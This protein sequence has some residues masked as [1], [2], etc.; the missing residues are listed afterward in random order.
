VTIAVE[1]VLRYQRRCSVL[2]PVVVKCV[3]IG[4]LLLLV[5]IITCYYCWT[6]RCC[7]MDLCTWARCLSRTPVGT[8]AWR[9]TMAACNELKLTS[10]SSQVQ[11]RLIRLFLYTY[12]QAF[13]SITVNS[14]PSLKALGFSGVSPLTLCAIQI[15]LL[16][17]N[18]KLHWSSFFSPQPNTSFAFYLHKLIIQPT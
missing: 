9:V 5:F 13:F 7:R 14:F 16:I 17:Y 10:T 15:C 1:L 12:R 18:I 11:Q 6:C 8:A 2:S 4:L 3:I